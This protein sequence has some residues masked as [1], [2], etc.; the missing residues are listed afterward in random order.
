[1]FGLCALSGSATLLAGPLLLAL[2]TDAFD[3]QRAGMASRLTFFM[4]DSA[5]LLAMRG[6]AKP[7]ATHAG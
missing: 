5:L 2:T 4:V 1:M 7:A 3:S 6:R